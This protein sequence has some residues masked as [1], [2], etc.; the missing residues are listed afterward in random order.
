M[1]SQVKTAVITEWP[2]LNLIQAFA[3][4]I[5]PIQSHVI[6]GTGGDNHEPEVGYEV[7]ANSGHKSFNDE[8]IEPIVIY[9]SDADVEGV[10][11]FIWDYNKLFNK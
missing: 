9:P 2:A 5:T 10:A 7:Q 6:E 1:S 4:G 3:G 11:S 8:R